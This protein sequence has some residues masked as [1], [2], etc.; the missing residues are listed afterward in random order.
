MRREP[1]DVV[2]IVD[3]RVPTPVHKYP[4]ATREEFEDI[5]QAVLDSP[6][7]DLTK[8][9]DCLNIALEVLGGIA[10]GDSTAAHDASQALR[11][12][13]QRTIQGEI[14]ADVEARSWRS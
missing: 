9:G 4:P 11:L 8:I 7:N 2:D 12:M 6:W 3:F 13:Q 5:R 10:T 14:A 1:A